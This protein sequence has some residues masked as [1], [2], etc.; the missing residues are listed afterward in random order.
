MVLGDFVAL[1]GRGEQGEGPGHGPER[2]HAGERVE[3]GEGMEELV[4]RGGR[5]HVRKLRRDRGEVHD[6]LEP[7]VVAGDAQKPVREQAI[8]QQPGA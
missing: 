6:R 5:A 3:A 1:K 8:Q 7:E 2:A 4:K